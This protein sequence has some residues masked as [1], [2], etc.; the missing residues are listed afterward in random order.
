MSVAIADLNADGKLDL[1]ANT[2][3]SWIGVGDFAKD[4][5]PDLVVTSPGTDQAIKTPSGGAV[6]D[7]NGDGFTD[8]A[9]ANSGNN[10]VAA[11]TGNG[12]GGFANTIA[13]NVGDRRLR[14]RRQAGPRR[15]QP[16]RR[17]RQRPLQQRQRRLPG[18]RALL[19]LQRPGV[20]RQRRLPRRRAPRST[21]VVAD[22][23]G[24]GKDDVAVTAQ[25]D[26]V[27]DVLLQK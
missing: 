1:A 26:N 20:A 2:A 24:D 6:G 15:R 18:R 8:L 25:T 27:V 16:G 3:P 22:L 17:H 9:T 7:L 5:R 4:G 11:L 13:N 14:R 12:N 23:D 10:V 21:L 19:G